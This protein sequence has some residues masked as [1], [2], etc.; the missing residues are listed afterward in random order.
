MNTAT[1][2][3]REAPLTYTNRIEEPCLD[4]IH[5]NPAT[6]DEPNGHALTTS[7]RLLACSSLPGQTPSSGPTATL[8]YSDSP[9]MLLERL[10]SLAP[11]LSTHGEVTPIQAWNEIRYHPDFEGLDV[12]VVH[13]LAD[14]LK[15]A[16]KCHGF[17][18]TIP[19]PVFTKLMCDTLIRGQPGARATPRD[20]NQYHPTILPHAFA[21]TIERLRNDLDAQR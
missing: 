1:R 15:Q 14:K 19:Q 2:A 21:S 20:C 12:G 17:G 6:P 16:A 5:G 7:A 4:H 3:Y 8:S 13:T 9:T 18:A 10:L 11:D